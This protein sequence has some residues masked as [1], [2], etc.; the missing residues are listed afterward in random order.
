MA[1]RRR[2]L[3]AV[4]IYLVVSLAGLRGTVCR[5][6]EEKP[7]L[8]SGDEVLTAAERDELYASLAEK[9][10]ALAP[11]L[12]ILKTVVK[13]V[14]PTVVHIKA[15]KKEEPTRRAR[16]EII[17][18]AGS[19]VVI[20]YKGKFYILTNRHVIKN[21]RLPD[22]QISLADGRELHP[23]KVW[24]DA[25]TDVALMAVSAPGLVA[26]RLGDSSAL[27][28]GDFVV[29]VGSPFGLSHSVTYGI[30]SAKGRR[31][32]ELGEDVRL[33]DFLQTDAAINPG[34]S[35]GPLINLKGEVIGINTAIASNSGGNEGIGFSIPINGVLHIVRQFIEKGR[36]VRA[37]VGVGLDQKFNTTVAV[38]LGLPRR[39]GAHITRIE[40]G[41]PAQAA[42]LLAGD[43]VLRF[44]GIRV[45]ND[46]HLIYLVSLTEVGK[47]VPL[48]IFRGG[49]TLQVTVRVGN[50]ASSEAAR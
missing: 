49:Q 3:T 23:H 46:A 10:E 44:D 2:S 8:P 18:E 47:E 37:Y 35:G 24:S 17:E 5:A 11:Q 13:L 4:A 32:L 39:Q 6:Q 9:A 25:D 42:R 12:N 29:A 45:E 28:I 27:E 22:I 20:D 33:Q 40:P 21:A 1:N 19:G 31:D 36:V 34:N 26:A 16:H 14:G 48:E 7:T 38:K 43:V 41:S 50:K 15:E 30:I